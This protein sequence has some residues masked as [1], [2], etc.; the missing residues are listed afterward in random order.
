M[1]GSNL[2]AMN[3]EDY[4]FIDKH[5][6]HDFREKGIK[7]GWE[8]ILYCKICSMSKQN[9][10]CTATNKYFAD[11][12]NTT[13]RNIQKYLSDLKIKGFIKSYEGKAGS[14]TDS[15]KIYPQLH[16]VNTV[17]NTDNENQIM[18][19]CS[20]NPCPTVH[21]THEQMDRGE[22]NSWTPTHEQLGHN[23][24]TVRSQP[25][26]SWVVT[27]EQ[28]DTQ[29][30]DSNSIVIDSNGD[31][32]AVAL[33]DVADAPERS[34]SL[35]HHLHTEADIME[36][37]FE[38]NVPDKHMPDIMKRQ[39]QNLLFRVADGDMDIN[40]MRDSMIQEFTTGFYKCKREPVSIY[41]DYLIT[42][43]GLTEK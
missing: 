40:D 33:L 31:A 20:H 38:G 5:K 15:R 37:K 29:V 7:N 39:Y 8:F 26:N 35:A 41:V 17:I 23:P 11:F 32:A 1:K 14:C 24:R 19:D 3:K 27:N 43:N 28:L 2:Q 9:G 22:V 6:I 42:H 36:L 10:F 18:N 21:P 30:I 12:V 34:A 25:T 4:V 13:E 16:K